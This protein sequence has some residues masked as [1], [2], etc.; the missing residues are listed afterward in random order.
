MFAALFMLML[1]SDA[2]IVTVKSMHGVAVGAKARTINRQDFVEIWE[3]E[4]GV[5][6]S[7]EVSVEKWFNAG[8]RQRIQSGAQGDSIA[9]HASAIWQDFG[10]AM[11]TPEAY[12]DDRRYWFKMNTYASST[13]SF[14][15]GKACFCEGCSMT[16]NKERL[17]QANFLPTGNG[18]PQ[19]CI[20]CAHTAALRL[21]S[22]VENYRQLVQWQQYALACAM[23]AYNRSLQFCDP[24]NDIVAFLEKCAPLV[25]ADDGKTISHFGG[26]RITPHQVIEYA[27]W[28][29][30]KLGQSI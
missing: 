1:R 26:L 16:K 15:K 19:L 20:G 6:V 4:G 21:Q 30:A 24:R 28:G 14:T 18:Y 23:L 25:C 12:Y 29:K 27:A 8:S 17:E 2:L 7:T 13:A 3:D 9:E 22:H 10:I 11:T 5:D